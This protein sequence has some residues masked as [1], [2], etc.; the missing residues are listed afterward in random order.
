MVLIKVGIIVT[1]IFL[2]S[3][4]HNVIYDES[5]IITTLLTQSYPCS[6]RENH[7]PWSILPSVN[8]LCISGR[9]P[10]PRPYR[11]VLQVHAGKTCRSHPPFSRVQLK[12]VWSK[13]FFLSH[14]HIVIIW[15]CP[16]NRSP[17]SRSSGRSS[18]VSM[19]TT[20]YTSTP[21]SFPT[22]ISGNF[23]EK[24]CVSVS[25]LSSLS[26][27]HLHSVEHTSPRDSIKKD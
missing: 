24:T 15:T 20:T 9:H 16:H 23:L 10:L 22:T 27:D 25:V 3:P 11:V 19:E 1:Y 26:K 17:N 14:P 12:F 7:L 21:P 8:W 4:L 6:F 2:I 13:L 5:L 18:R